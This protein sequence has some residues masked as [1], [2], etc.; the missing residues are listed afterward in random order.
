MY[1]N[2]IFIFKNSRT[3]TQPRIRNVQKNNCGRVV[4]CRS[5]NSSYSSLYCALLFRAQLVVAPPSPLA[6]SLVIIGWFYGWDD[7]YCSRWLRASA[8][9]ATEPCAGSHPQQQQ[10]RQSASQKVSD[11][12]AKQ[13]VSPCH[14]LSVQPFKH[15]N[16]LLSLLGEISWQRRKNMC[17]TL[18]CSCSLQEIHLCDTRRSA[19]FPSNNFIFHFS[20]KRLLFCFYLLVASDFNDCSWRCI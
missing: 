11:A 7:Y 15:L 16:I 9:P 18:V 12:S 20:T 10:Q 13:P 8:V 19:F 2:K 5:A 14:R 3:H 17:C 6:A 1:K 4:A